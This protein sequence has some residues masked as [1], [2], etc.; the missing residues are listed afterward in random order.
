M[1]FKIE[2]ISKMT[3]IANNISNISSEA[4]SKLSST[5]ATVDELVNNVKGQGVDT[6]LNK[7]RSG[8]NNTLNTTISLLSDVSTFISTQ[9]TSYTTNEQIVAQEL[10]A[11]DVALQG[12]EV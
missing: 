7:L 6:A 11:I 2:S 12:L 3:T 5:T 8:I 9:T 1:G 10:K 4:K